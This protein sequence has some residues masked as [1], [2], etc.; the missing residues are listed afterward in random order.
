[1][2]AFFNLAPSEIVIGLVIAILVFGRRLPEVAGQAAGQFQ[3]L[4][5]ALADLK[6]ETGIDEELR[7][8]RRS[9]E[10][11]V[12]RDSWRRTLDAPGHFTHQIERDIREAVERHRNDPTPASPEPPP[13]PADPGGGPAAPPGADPGADAGAPHPQGPGERR[14]PGA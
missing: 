1:M 10:D 5:R 8:A 3:K 6:R 13:P 11:V 4:R 12:P 7:A 9:I 14:G 2:L